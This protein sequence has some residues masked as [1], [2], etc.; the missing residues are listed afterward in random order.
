MVNIPKST[1]KLSSPFDG[2]LEF[3]AYTD[4][5]ECFIEQDDPE[6]EHAGLDESG[7]EALR[8]YLQVLL[9]PK[10]ASCLEELRVLHLQCLP[11]T[12]F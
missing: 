2:V 4:A 11:M 7:G 12:M 6:G 3:V 10:L 9:L 5:F 8:E 1:L